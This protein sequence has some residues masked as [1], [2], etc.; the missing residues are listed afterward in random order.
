MLNK[1]TINNFV[2]IENIDIDFSDKFNVIIGE[3]G[4]GKSILV[5]AL[6]LLFGEKASVDFIRQ[7]ESKSVI[8]AVFTFSRDSF[9]WKRISELD[10]EIDTLEVDNNQDIGEIII[11]REILIKGSSRC[12]INDTPVTLAILKEIS[13]D[14][15]DFHGQNTSQRLLEKNNQLS[16]LDD[17]ITDKQ[18]KLLYSELFINYQNKINDYHKLLK[19]KKEYL[20]KSTLLEAQLEEI[21]S[22]A[23]KIDEDVHLKNELTFL[24]N[25]E[26]IF[27]LASSFSEILNSDISNNLLKDLSEAKNK[28]EAL[29]NFDDRFKLYLEEVNTSIISLIETEKFVRSY[30]DSIEFNPIRIDEIR[31]R[32]SKINKLKNKYGDIK[33]IL[34]LKN[35]IENQLQLIENYDDNIK[36]LQ[37]DLK[38]INKKIE[39][40]SIDLHNIRT[41]HAKNFEKKVVDKLFD[42]GI[43]NAKFEIRFSFDETTEDVFFNYSFPAICYQEKYI[44]LIDTGYDTIEFYISTN[45]GEALSPISDTASGGE[46]SRIMLAIKSIIAETYKTPILIFDEI[47]TGIS[48]RI[49]QKVGIAMRELANYHQVIT[50]T[51]LPQI[52][53]LSNNCLAIY[54]QEIKER[55]IATAKIL[56]E[57]EKISEIAKMLSGEILTESAIKS[58]KELY[59]LIL[60]H[61]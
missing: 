21:N 59:S 20:Q 55:T 54:K 6:M 3:T 35:N 49:A 25:S 24:E 13:Q 41:T 7:G 48:G 33:N 12:F 11:R 29:Y 22:V 10:I 32:L 39:N 40:I 61:F 5:D 46:I 28:L 43:K 15:V 47:D 9:M 57:K 26:T 4:A 51:H 27:S 18:V 34:E 50:I 60:L 56:G 30:K 58:A 8:E 44:K 36:T 31:N 17:F 14:L 2:I 23:P 38:D 42:L 52:A 1:L 16:I 53:A 37:I 45:K 19:Q